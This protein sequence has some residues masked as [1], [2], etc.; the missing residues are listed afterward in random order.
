MGASRR[1][2]GEVSRTL[3]R[4]ELEGRLDDVVRRGGM[5]AL[6]AIRDEAR[7][8]APLLDRDKEFAALDR[9]VGALLGTREDRLTSDRAKA[10]GA[11]SL[12][13][14]SG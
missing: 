11:G 9:M 13:I 14:P 12:S 1:R 3:S 7:R 4:E 6:N 10:R 8:I 5:E 2:N